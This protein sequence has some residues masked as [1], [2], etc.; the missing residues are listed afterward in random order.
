MFP[1]FPCLP[2]KFANRVQGVSDAGVPGVACLASRRAAAF[3]KCFQAV[4]D[5]QAIDE[6]N[7]LVAD[8]PRQPHAQRSTVAYWKLAAIHAVTEEWL[9]MQHVGHNDAGP[10]IWF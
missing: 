3:T 4:C 1:T 10:R 2:A 9:G 8:L 7:V 5:R 6:F